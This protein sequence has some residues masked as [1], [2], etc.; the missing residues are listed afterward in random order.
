M[1]A[2]LQISV[3][4]LKLILDEAI[5][6]IIFQTPFVSDLADVTPRSYILIVADGVW[7]LLFDDESEKTEFENITK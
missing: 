5:F 4:H 2:S 6:L 7:L 3:E 1:S